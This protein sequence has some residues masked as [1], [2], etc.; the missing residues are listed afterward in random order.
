MNNP[1]EA[2]GRVA[3][4]VRVEGET[5]QALRELADRRHMSVSELAAAILRESLGHVA[6]DRLNGPALP[7]VRQAIDEALKPHVERLAALIA[8]THLEAGIAERLAYVLVA[9]A[10]GAEKAPQYLDAARTKAVEAL[11]RP[12]G[13][14]RPTE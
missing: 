1:V 2:G 4:T 6:A 7:A 10:F 14:Q 11:K 8:K 13:E 12:L 5:A 3:L 9:Q